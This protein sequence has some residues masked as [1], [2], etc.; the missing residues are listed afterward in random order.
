[1]MI[2]LKIQLFLAL[3]IIQ[4]INSLIKSK[5]YFFF[6]DLIKVITNS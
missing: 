1:M 6:L 4:I 3:I 5:K 2:K